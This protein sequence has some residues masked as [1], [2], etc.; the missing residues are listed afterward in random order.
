[1]RLEDW[2]IEGMISAIEYIFRKNEIPIKDTALYLYGSRVDD[3]KRG[4]DID[5]IL[6]VS[7]SIF[8]QVKDKY[9]DINF[10][11]QRR[12]GEQKIDFLI[13]NLD[14]PQDPFHRLAL[15]TA[16]LIKQWK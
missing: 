9:L 2:E 7:D 6:R 11:M 3:Q 10:Q 12:I 1:M 16:V 14:P 5:L 4:G 15:K 8:K 13:L